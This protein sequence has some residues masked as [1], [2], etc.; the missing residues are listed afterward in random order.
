MIRILSIQEFEEVF[1]DETACRVYLAS[2]RWPDGF[3]CPRC[4]HREYTYVSTRQLFECKVCSYQCSLISS[5]IFQDTKL[6]LRTWFW[7]IYFLVTMKKS[8]S[9]M[10]LMRKLG[11]GSYGTAWHMHAKIQHALKDNDDTILRGIVE[12]DETLYGPNK[13]EPGRSRS[14]AVIAVA[15]EDKGEYAGNLAIKHV[16]DASG[17][18]LS[19]FIEENV[20]SGSDLKTD[21][22]IGYNSLEDLGYMHERII[23]DGPKDASEKLPWVHIVVSNLKRVLNGIY[24]GVSRKHLDKY[25]QTFAFRFKFRRTLGDAMYEAMNKLSTTPPI[26]YYQLTSEIPA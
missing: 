26:T 10:E 15:V 19:G 1:P 16:P 11:L 23:L 14:K 6:P 21:G 5:T 17:D 7:A 3:E 18:S 2:T 13:G 4:G 20:R 25:L 22:W 8:M 9:A 24:A 12:A